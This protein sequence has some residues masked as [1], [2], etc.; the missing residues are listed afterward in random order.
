LSE[1]LFRGPC[2]PRR[3]WPG[4]GAD[5]FAVV[6]PD[7]VTIDDVRGQADRLL[8]TLTYLRRLP[9]DIVK[10]A[11]P[12]ADDLAQP[13]G[14][15][16]FVEA[17]ISLGHTLGLTIVAEGIEHPEQAVT[18]TALGCQYGQGYVF[19]RPVPAAQLADVNH[20]INHPIDATAATI[21]PAPAHH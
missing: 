17:I 15:T 9:L 1:A 20:R 12:F 6:I 4:L 2:R 11:Q 8:A 14:D 21:P 19:S 3:R 10:I 18:L 13:A 5:E 16:S 7:V